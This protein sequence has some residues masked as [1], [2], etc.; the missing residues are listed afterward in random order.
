MLNI[1]SP[2]RLQQHRLFPLLSTE[3]AAPLTQMSCRR[4]CH[5]SIH[6]RQTIHIVISVAI[7]R[8][9]LYIKQRR[10][11]RSNKHFIILL[12]FLPNV[13][14]PIFPFGLKFT[15]SEYDACMTEKDYL[16]TEHHIIRLVSFRQRDNEIKYDLRW[17]VSLTV[18]NL[19]IDGEGKGGFLKHQHFPQPPSPQTY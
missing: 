18:L 14:L 4:T 2:D 5:R 7:S 6:I 1:S 17:S 12:D 3:T 19:I 8:G 13:W 10:D 16:Q 15:N 9:S 11:V